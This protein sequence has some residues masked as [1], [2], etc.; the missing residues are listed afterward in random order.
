MEGVPRR[1]EQI[2]SRRGLL[3]QFPVPCTPVTAVIVESS[4]TEETQT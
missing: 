2:D 1:V 4:L 3:D